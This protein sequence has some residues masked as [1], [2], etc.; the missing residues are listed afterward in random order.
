M[1]LKKKRFGFIEGRGCADGRKQQMYKSKQETSV[2]TV[3][4][5][6]LMLS[7]AI[8]A[9]EKRAIITADIL[10][11]FMQADMD[12]TVHMK[13][14]GP[15]VDLLVKVNAEKYGKFVSSKNGKMVIYVIL[16]KA[17]YGTL[18][19][20]LLFWKNLSGKLLQWGFVLNP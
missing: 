6:S 18:Q 3:A 1:F 2:P 8:D 16:K 4:I 15:M 7:C 5:E 17:L 12:D 19:A 20:A 10:G 13:I 11:A 9:K 14:V